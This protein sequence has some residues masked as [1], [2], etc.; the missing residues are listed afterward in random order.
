[1][2]KRYF[3]LAGGICA[4]L[5]ILIAV[6]CG[7][8]A[9]EPLSAQETSYVPVSLTEEH[10]GTVLTI[11]LY[12][13]EK[14]LLERLIE[15]SFAECERL[16]RIFSA[17]LE[18]SELSELNKTAWNN[19]TAVSE[20]LFEVF[21]KALYYNACS[22]GSLDISIGKL[23]RLWG[24]GTEGQRVPDDAELVEMAG[25]NGCQY[26]LL[27]ET[28]KTI[29]YTDECVEVDLGAIAKGYAA[30]VIKEYILQQ[31]PQVTGILNFG[32]NIMT[33]GEKTDGSAWNIGITNPFSPSEVYASVSVRNQCVVTSGNYERYFMEGGKRYHH[34]LD[35]QTG[36][37]AKQGIIS[38]TI[39]GDYSADCDALSTACYILGIEKALS[40]IETLDGVEAVLIDEEG[41][42]HCSSGIAQYQLQEMKGSS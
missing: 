18:D 26:I 20:E 22:E 28:E 15:N 8:T 16:E 12:G 31:K 39:I 11:T 3:I 1:M 29:T 13:N 14:E 41:D 33:I 7:H 37:P 27:D 25:K 38:A 30:D 17:K 35:P 4:V 34:I 32:G 5:V 24:I 40:F 42:L 10:F 23:I 9:K 21:Q 36:Y 2:K 6:R 19:P